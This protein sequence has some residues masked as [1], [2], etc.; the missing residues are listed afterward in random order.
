[1][2]LKTIW[3]VI[4]AAGSAFDILDLDGDGQVTETELLAAAAVLAVDEKELSS[5]YAK[6]SGADKVLQRP[7]LA[8]L[9][10]ELGAD[11]TTIHEQQQ[12]EGEGGGEQDTSSNTTA[13]SVSGPS[14]FVS[15]GPKSATNA[16][17]TP[18]PAAAA[19][20]EEAEVWPEELVLALAAYCE[21]AYVPEGEVVVHVFPFGGVRQ[22]AEMLG[23]LRR[24]DW[25]SASSS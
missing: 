18:T 9:L 19:A 25:P 12:L 24:G 15:D 8:Q 10:V 16:S 17:G 6:Y 4:T 11:M 5:L 1:M 20:V 23:R 14:A 2:H 22:S 3:G 13:H 21:Q 7:E